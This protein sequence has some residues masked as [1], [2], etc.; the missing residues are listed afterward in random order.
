VCVHQRRRKPVHARIPLLALHGLCTSRGGRR[1]FKDWGLLIL[2]GPLT[3]VA[4]C[5][6]GSA[7]P[8]YLPEET[9]NGAVADIPLKWTRLL[10]R[11]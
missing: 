1:A 5:D 11:A 4:T 3:Y 2:S 8:C 10:G 7:L 9:S 6:C